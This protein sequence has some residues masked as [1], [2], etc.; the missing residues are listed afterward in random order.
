MLRE[1][2]TSEFRRSI[3]MS[4]CMSIGMSICMSIGMSIS[5]SIENKQADLLFERPTRRLMA[6]DNFPSIKQSRA[7]DGHLFIGICS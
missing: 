4:N 7:S 5:M 6:T 2:I 1:S 3:H